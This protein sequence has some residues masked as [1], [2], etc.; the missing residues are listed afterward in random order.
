M[1]YPGDSPPS[2][3]DADVDAF[4]EPTVPAVYDEM[5]QYAD[6]T[7]WETNDQGGGDWSGGADCG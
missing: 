2:Y 1:S 6:D 4:L 5:E 3:P 7:C